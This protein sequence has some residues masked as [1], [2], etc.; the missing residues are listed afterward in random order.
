LETQLL[1]G[2]IEVGAYYNENNPFC[3]EWIRNLI[4]AS[5]IP[6]GVVDE[7]SIEEVK[8][9]DLKG[10][11]QCHFFAGI[12]VWAYAL[13]EA[14][15]PDYTQVWTGSCPCQPF[16]IAGNREEFGDERD[17]W[18]IWADLIR[19]CNPPIIIGE[20]VASKAGLVWF[21]LLSTD[22]E[23]ANYSVGAANLCAA[24]VGAPHRRQRLYWLAH[25]E[26]D[27]QQRK[28]QCSGAPRRVGRS[29]QPL[30][31]N[32]PW[33]AALAKFRAVDDGITRSVATTDVYR[34]A[35]VAPLASEF[36]AAVKDILL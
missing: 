6:P 36:C 11:E 14:R 22:L 15:W 30:P 5:Y 19:E 7:R 33:P 31:W 29:N 24:G 25:A 8:P 26:W 2:R 9:Q 10:F 23:A 32:T 3:A 35:I 13:R 28:E 34:N 20:Q 18:P 17:L 4:E 1:V 27:K 16:S 12:G 21:D